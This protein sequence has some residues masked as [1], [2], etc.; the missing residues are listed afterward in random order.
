MISTSLRGP[1]LLVEDDD[2][3]VALIRRATKKAKLEHP[4]KVVRDG[5]AAISYLRGDGEFADRNIYPLP[6]LVLLD[7]KLRRKNGLEVLEWLRSQDSLK[8]I[9][10]IM[11]TSSRE[12]QDVNRAYDLGAN[13]YLVKPATFGAL[14]L[15]V[16]NLG[17]YWLLLNECP[18]P[19]I[20]QSPD[21]A[22][23]DL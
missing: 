1:I 16:Q 12:T 5:E 4:M 6:G 15:L 17:S 8:R 7:V 11:L 13:S 23:P 9:L 18:D 19:S 3:D 21:S 2:N 22:T 20:V 10:V 14:L